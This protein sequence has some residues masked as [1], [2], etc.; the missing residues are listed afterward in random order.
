MELKIK[1]SPNT[2]ARRQIQNTTQRFLKNNFVNPDSIVN[3]YF[4]SQSKIRDLNKKYRQIDKPTDVLSFPIWPK[5]SEIPKKGK[6]ILGDIFLFLKP[7]QQENI[8]YLVEHSL[9]HLI[10]KHH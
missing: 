10:G 2:N 5:K 4:V 9:N 3:V 7:D 8:A 6:I 1:N